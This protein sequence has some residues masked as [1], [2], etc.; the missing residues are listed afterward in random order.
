MRKISTMFL[1]L[2]LFMGVSLNAQDLVITAVFDADL[3]GGTPKG[4]ELY[5]LSDI[6][7]LSIYGLGSANNGGGSDGEEFTFPAD[8]ASEGDFIYVSSEAPNF[9]AWFGFDPNYTSSAMEINGNDAVELFMN[10]SVIDVFGEIDTDGT[11]EPWEYKDGWAYRNNGTGPDGSTFVLGNFDCQNGALDGESSNATAANPVPVGTYTPG[12]ATTVSTPIITPA[13]GT[14]TDPVTVE[15]TCGTDGATIYYTTDGSD[16]DEGDAEYTNGFTVSTTTTVKARAYK[17][18]LDASNIAVNE[19]TFT[20]VTEVSTIADLRAQ[21]IGDTYY[22]LTGEAVLTFQQSYRSQKFIQD[23]TAAIKIDDND[24]NI[25]TEYN[26]YDGITG[27]TGQLS[28]YGDMLQFIPTED[29]GSA[30]STGNTIVPQVVTLDDLSADFEDYEAELVKVEGA[31]FADAGGTFVTG[32]VYPISDAS[33]ASY[34]FR[35]SF[36]SV[37]YIGETIPSGA[38]DLVLLPDSRTDGEYVVSRSA[39]DMTP[40]SGGNPASQ[41]SITSVNNGNAVYENQEFSVTVQSQDEDGVAANV[42]AD[43]EITISLETGTGTLGGTLTG[44]IADGSSTVTISGITYGP[45]ENGVVLNANGG[46]LSQ[47]V[48][49]PFDVLEVVVADLV[50]TEIMYNGMPGTDTLEYIELYNNG[51]SAL[52]LENYY[53]SEGVTHVFSNVSINAGGY[54]LVAVNASAI[55]DVFGVS[56][57]EWT[58]GGLS[59]SGEDIELRDPSDMVVAYVDYGVSDPWPAKETGKSIRFCDPSLANNEAANWTISEEYVTTINEQ[60]IYGTPLADCGAA[61]QPPVANFEADNT[62]IE[63]GDAVQFT[64]LSTNSPTS[65]L[66]TFEGGT[67]A[68]STE[69]NPSVIYANEGVYDVT[70]YVENADG[71]DTEVKVDYIQVSVPIIAPVAEFTSDQT[72]IFVGQ[73]IQFTDQSSNNPTDWTWTFE[74]GTPATSNAQNPTVMYN[75][76][77]TYDVTLLVENSAGS[78]ELLVGDMITVLP[79][80]V[81]DL[82]ITEIMYNPPEDGDDS[83]EYIE[84]YNNS[85]ES[86]NL[87]EYE[88]SEGVDFVFPDMNIESGDYLVIAK[89]ADAFYNTFGFT[90]LQWTSGALSN[91]GE[92][93]KLINPTGVTIDSVPYQKVAPWPTNAAGDGPS[94]TIC[95]PNTENSVGENWHA[96]VNYLADNEQGVAIY[97]SPAMAPAPVAD[98]MADETSFAGTGQVEFTEM[99]TCNAETFAWEFEGGTPATSTEANPTV[100]YSMAGD[101]DV[102]LTVSNATGS[103]TLTMADYIHIGVGLSEQTMNQITVIPNP[104]NGHFKLQNPDR[105]MMEVEVYN[106]LGKLISESETKDMVYDLDLMSE[107]NGIYFVR[108]II[109]EQIKTVKII[110][111]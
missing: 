67:P 36:Y 59:N 103:H 107:E 37:D 32:T 51:S 42:D 18:G 50:I 57:V 9:N 16:P 58:S 5:A 97:G 75:T 11:G 28:E 20:S 30:T 55:Q 60:G 47:G 91:G 43:T 27:I 49:A 1:M 26:L 48:S 21:D 111:Q 4:V 104:S 19:Y 38:Q 93:I 46:S 86:L 53:F 62:S 61:S 39:A 83:L 76:A 100:T 109:G 88:F 101:F 44:T 10:G 22:K 77:G 2:L 99:A 78:D 71:N 98:F 64:D 6:A 85:T 15:M 52:N 102:T 33:K 25:T 45:H 8:A 13:S 65:Y 17:S 73:S 69:Q 29:P 105:M 106:V 24:G 66:W 41:L 70:L 23:A 56:A 68:T 74:G 81:G 34:N 94:I 92:L 12:A 35:T 14:Y 84:I 31:V 96:S 54:L 87:Y 80:T 40:S 90:V 3:S 89:N 79:A 63:E 110:K 7:D 95:D 108:I 72:V 82:V